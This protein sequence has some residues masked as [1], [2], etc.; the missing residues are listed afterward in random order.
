MR[1][2]RY[3]S[4]MSDAPPAPSRSMTTEEAVAWLQGLGRSLEEV[5]DDLLSSAGTFSAV[6]AVMAV[7]GK[8]LV[9]AR[10]IV[11]KRK[12]ELLHKEDIAASSAWVDERV[13][14][15][16]A[17]MRTW[18]EAARM[19]ASNPSSGRTPWEPTG[20]VERATVLS[21]AFD[22]PFAEAVQ[23]VVSSS[24]RSS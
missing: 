12:F 22:L 1:V 19:L 17:S 16:R 21:R 14:A 3:S 23:L 2:I 7:Y 4:T 11:E 24:E 9:G 8:D 18:Q 5:L 13:K 15:V 6:Q 20:L 10:G